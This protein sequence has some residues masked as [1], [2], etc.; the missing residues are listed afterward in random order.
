MHRSRPENARALDNRKRRENDCS[1]LNSP[2]GKQETTTAH[3]T[4]PP[5]APLLKDK[6]VN[7]RS[8]HSYGHGT[9]KS[10]EKERASSASTSLKGPAFQRSKLKVFSDKENAGRTTKE[11]P[12][13]LRK[14]PNVVPIKR[15]SSDLDTSSP[16]GKRVETESPSTK[17]I[18]RGFLQEEELPYLPDVEIDFS[19]FNDRLNF[20][21][22]DTTAAEGEDETPI[23]IHLDTND[24]W[25][26]PFERNDASPLNFLRSEEAT[27][28]STPT[29]TTETKDELKHEAKLEFPSE[30]EYAP[31][32]EKE[33]AYEPAVALDVS[34]FSEMPYLVAYENHSF[35]QEFTTL[36]TTD[37]DDDLINRKISLNAYASKWLE[38]EIE[39]NGDDDND[40]EEFELLTD[41]EQDPFFQ[42]METMKAEDEPELFADHLFDVN[43]YPNDNNQQAATAT[44]N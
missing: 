44:A 31:P 30:I 8:V 36:D 10:N 28:A 7:Q 13:S 17:A 24:E 38:C 3:S 19:A 43:A 6:D 5:T 27:K 40:T 18:E 37:D 39:D 21:A 29:E 9:T 25:D 2:I 1:N 11:T 16:V 22:Y 23:K 41:L 26:I 35:D 34:V 15:S 33:L 4:D 20:D 32:K 42:V 14:K 12:S